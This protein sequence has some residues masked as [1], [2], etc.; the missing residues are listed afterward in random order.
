MEGIRRED[1]RL[2]IKFLIPFKEESVK[3]EGEKYPTL[4][5]AVPSL[6]R[7]RSHCLR[8]LRRAEDEEESAPYR[9]IRTKALRLLDDKVKIKMAHKVATFLLPKY[10][11]LPRLSAAEREEVIRIVCKFSEKKKAEIFNT[12]FPA[13]R[14]T[15]RSGG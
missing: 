3:L 5:L 11:K 9:V 12:P 13:S 15:L 6:H 1:V 7:L 8:Q 4:P 2:F 14:Y 10:R